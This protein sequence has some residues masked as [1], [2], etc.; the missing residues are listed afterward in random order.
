MEKSRLCFL[1]RLDMKEIELLE[2]K[3]HEKGNY[4]TN[5]INHQFGRVLE[6]QPIKEGPC[7]NQ[8]L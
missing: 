6:R 2:R 8:E 5:A 1:E 7:N 4:C 3:T